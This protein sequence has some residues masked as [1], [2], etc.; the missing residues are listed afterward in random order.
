M[1]YEPPPP[2]PEPN[3]TACTQCTRVPDNGPRIYADG[4][5]FCTSGCLNKWLEARVLQQPY[6]GNS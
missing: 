2:P 4:G 1:S 5:Q 3:K 6:L